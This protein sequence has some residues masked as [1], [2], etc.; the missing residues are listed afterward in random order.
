MHCRR[1]F[2]SAVSR[3]VV[4]FLFSAAL[5]QSAAAQ[6]ALF[7]TERLAT[8][9][10]GVDC[11]TELTRIVRDLDDRNLTRDIRNSQLG[12]AAAILLDTAKTSSQGA[13]DS[14]ASSMLALASASSEVAQRQSMRAAAFEIRDGRL[15]LE[16]PIDAVA[17][18]PD[19]AQRRF[20]RRFF[21]RLRSGRLFNRVRMPRTF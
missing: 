4:A 13:Q 16:T 7:D 14:I 18:S 8:A 15:D 11:Q 10:E 6:E 21:R 19:R 5:I 3:F 20:I 12:L 17:V 2:Q 9:C 1:Q